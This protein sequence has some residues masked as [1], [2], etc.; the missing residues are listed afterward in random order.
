MLINFSICMIRTT[1]G[2]VCGGGHDDDDAF[3]SDL[4]V[5][6]SIAVRSYRR[7]RRR[8]RRRSFHLLQTHEH[9]E[10]LINWT[11]FEK[12]GVY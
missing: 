1:V 2:T 6:F 12:I 11:S 5:A 8:R 3:C 4:C 7:C 10:L 9:T